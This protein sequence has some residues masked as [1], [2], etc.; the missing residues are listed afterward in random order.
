MS[1]FV[2]EVTNRANIT[3]YVVFSPEGIKFYNGGLAADVTRFE[4]HSLAKTF[5]E[6]KQLDKFGDVYIR[7]EE[8]VEKREKERGEELLKTDLFY[9][10]LETGEKL[11]HEPK[12]QKY[13]FENGDAGFCVSK[14]KEQLEQLIV[15]NKLQGKAT[16]KKLEKQS[17]DN[18][19][20]VK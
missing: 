15:F 18:L 13:F 10:E 6:E 2:I 20:I 14:N 5:F 7:T 1:K 3:A 9:I 12:E 19:K 4:S 11:F 8:Y 17:P 16:V